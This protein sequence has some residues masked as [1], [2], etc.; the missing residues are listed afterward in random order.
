MVQRGHLL[1]TVEKTYDR[2]QHG[3]KGKFSAFVEE[4]R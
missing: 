4:H 2:T 3:K 1:H